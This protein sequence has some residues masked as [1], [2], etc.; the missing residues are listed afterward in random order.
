MKVL[1]ATTNKGKRK[2]FS[3][4]LA[5]VN[6]QLVFP[7][8]IGISLEVAETGS[9]YTENALLKARRCATPVD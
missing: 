8:E 3:S 4:L 7:D 5:G 6:F 1:I 9:T 2:E